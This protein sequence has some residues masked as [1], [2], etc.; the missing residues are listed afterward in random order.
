M[1]ISKKE[2]NDRSQPERMTILINMDHPI[3]FYMTFRNDKLSDSALVS[4]SCQ[5]SVVCYSAD[6]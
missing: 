5:L 2:A 1:R 3:F 4:D 6:N